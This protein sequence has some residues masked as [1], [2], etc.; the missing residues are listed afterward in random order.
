MSIGLKVNVKVSGLDKLE[1]DIKFLEKYS[2]ISTDSK[3]Q[4]YIQQKFLDTVNEMSARLLVGGELTS[5]YIS[6][7]KIRPLEDGFILYNDAFVET[8]S[9]G[10][11]GKFCIALAFEYGTGLV[12]Q[13]NPKEGAWQYNVKG[14]TKG[15]NY[16]KDGQFIFTRGMQ[17]Y[18]IYRFTKEEINKRKYD[19]V[20]SYIEE[21]GG[22]S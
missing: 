11:G 4:K 7:N 16:F 2:R 5:E 9:E 12:G 19:W 18:E 13:E 14:H 1:K 15:W 10:Y 20:K 17:G 22:V 6:N 8:D 3:F 21:N